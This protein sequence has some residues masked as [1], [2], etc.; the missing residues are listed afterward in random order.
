MVNSVNMASIKRF[1]VNSVNYSYG[2]WWF[3]I[4]HDLS[5]NCFF[6]FSEGH[7]RPPM[8]PC[9]QVAP[10]GVPDPANHPIKVATSWIRRPWRWM[11]GPIGSGKPGVWSKSNCLNQQCVDRL[12]DS[13][14]T[15]KCSNNLN[16]WA[17]LDLVWA[18]FSLGSC[19]FF[20][21]I[22]QW[23]LSQEDFSASTQ[24]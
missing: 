4:N 24:T 1:M 9:S 5:K 12:G 6:R 7:L 13:S 16:I 22:T 18:K 23:C 11:V 15:V 21:D 2:Y 20:P 17:G 8:T 3:I 14:T 10:S 19:A